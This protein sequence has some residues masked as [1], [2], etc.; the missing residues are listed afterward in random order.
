M[1]YRLSYVSN[2]CDAYS[3]R[4]SGCYKKEGKIVSSVLRFVYSLDLSFFVIYMCS[5]CRPT[6]YGILHGRANSPSLS[7]ELFMFSLLSFM[8]IYQRSS[9]VSV[10]VEFTRVFLFY[11]MLL[12]IYD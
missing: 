5:F 7:F 2:A 1:L 11:F 10:S 12:L 4:H 3:C 6:L 9:E 8:R